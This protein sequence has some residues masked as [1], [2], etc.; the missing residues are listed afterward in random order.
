VVVAVVVVAVVVVVVVVLVVIV[1]SGGGSSSSII[2]NG[3]SS[4][5]SSGGV[6][7]SIKIDRGNANYSSRFCNE[8]IY[9]LDMHI[10]LRIYTK[11][12]LQ[13]I[14]LRCVTPCILSHFPAFHRSL[15]TPSSTVKMDAAGSCDTCVPITTAHQS[16]RRC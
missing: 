14:V 1:V 8:T 6:V 11:I 5:S 4:S 15:L 16:V 3:S 10:K 7:V 9:T 13:N 12:K 2:S